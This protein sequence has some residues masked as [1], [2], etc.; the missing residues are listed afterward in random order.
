[1]GFQLSWR[2]WLALVALGPAV[3]LAVQA[4]PLLRSVVL[5]LLLT[6][7]L[8]LL[9]SPL[10]DQLERRGLSRGLTTGLTLFGG[11]AVLAGL[12]L[13]LLPILF[14]SLGMLAAN[15]ETLAAQLPREIEMAMRSAEVGALASN[16][17][18]Q[19]AAAL[20][21]AAQYV[22]T[23]VGQIGFLGFATF[24]SF[25]IVFA[26]V[27]NRDTAPALMRV[28]M[29]ARYHARAIS[30]T[31][32]VS[33]GLSRWFVAQLAICG[34]YAVTYSAVNLLFGV[35]FGVQIGV[36]AGLLEFIP[37]LGGLVGMVL[38]VTAAATVSPTTALLVWI[39]QAAIG[40][41][42]VYFVAPYAFAKA[43][44]VPPALILFGLFVGGLLG[45]FFAALLTV[46]LI[47][48][49]LVVL[50]ELRPDLRPEQPKISKARRTPVT[51]RGS[52]A[53]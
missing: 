46:P 28:F 4:L 36:V 7:F 45:G 22:G 11:L 25:S 40:A 14:H 38:S 35:P 1:M 15:L 47:A 33:A 37:Y 32:A 10:A 9:I 27:G 23:L 43:V 41:G 50:R 29:P 20:Q 42:C 39:C 44:D 30:L 17:T 8:A 12:V 18:S 48:S 21:A 51:G 5:L 31:R 3:F 13:L 34:Y 6:V 52:E 26:L 2:T 53:P 24:V 16:V 19:V 49:G